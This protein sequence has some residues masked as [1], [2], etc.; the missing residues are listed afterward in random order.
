MVQIE[1]LE[2]LLSRPPNEQRVFVKR[3]NKRLSPAR[4]RCAAVAG[5]RPRSTRL[6]GSFASS[7]LAEVICYHLGSKHKK[8]KTEQADEEIVCRENGWKARLDAGRVL[9]VHSPFRL[10][11]PSSRWTGRL[12]R[13]P[14]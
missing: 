1:R 13:G 12:S 9:L 11:H 4:A 14:R 8:L 5:Q 3:G 2:Y 6:H 10:L 7:G